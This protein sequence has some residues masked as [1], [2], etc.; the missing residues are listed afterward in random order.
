MVNLRSDT[1][2]L[3]SGVVSEAICLMYF[4]YYYYNRACVGKGY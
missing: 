3:S 1:R 4:R 2:T